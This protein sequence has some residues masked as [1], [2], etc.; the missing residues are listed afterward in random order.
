MAG[1]TPYESAK[2][3]FTK[4]AELLGVDEVRTSQHI[5]GMTVYVRIGSVWQSADI[6]FRVLRDAKNMRDEIGKIMFEL[7]RNMKYKLGID[8]LSGADLDRAAALVGVQREPEQRRLNR[9][10][11]VVEELEKL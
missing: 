9:F 11:A 1:E 6:N 3:G 8:G 2:F 5:G 10:E 7:T 4:I